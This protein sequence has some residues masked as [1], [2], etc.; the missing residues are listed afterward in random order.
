MYSVI[1]IA[2]KLQITRAAVYKKLQTHKTALEGH[3]II[4]NRGKKIDEEGISILFQTMGRNK[5]LSTGDK[6]RV[7]QKEVVTV[8]KVDTTD[9]AYVDLLKQNIIDLKQN[10]ERLENDKLELNKQLEKKDNQLDRKDNQLD[11]EQE[12]NK[13]LLLSDGK[14]RKGLFWWLKK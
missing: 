14:N 7:K 6:Q 4:D 12:K 13:I 3:I 5:N 10:I 9:N 1:E 8:D 11:N 2:K